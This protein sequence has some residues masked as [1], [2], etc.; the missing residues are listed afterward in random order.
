MSKKKKSKNS[1]YHYLQRQYAEQREQRE[2]AERD[3]KKKTRRLLNWLSFLLIVVSVI[4]AFYSYMNKA[5]EL[6]P[7]YTLTSAIA[8]MLMAWTAKDTRP[9]FYKVGMGIGV[10]LIVLTY[11]TTKQAGFLF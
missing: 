6:A 11:F 5:T 10:V 4:M 2:K 3:S 8:M 1:D 9:T 7:I